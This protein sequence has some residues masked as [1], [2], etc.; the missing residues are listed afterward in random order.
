MADIAVIHMDLM[1]K[2]GGEAVCMHVLESLEEDHDVTL[3]TLSDPDLDALNDYFRTDVRSITVELAGRLG[4]LLHRR[5]DL[6]YYV[7][8]NALLGRYARDRSADFDLQISTINEL[9][10][11]DDSIEYVHFPFDW[12]VALDSEL[13]EQ[14]FHPTIDAGGLYERLCT[15]VA[16][17]TPESFEESTV[18]ANSAWTA[19]AVEN[20]YGTR[21]DVVYPPVDTRGFDDRS[22]EEREPGFVTIGRIE[23]SK[24]IRELVEIVDGVREQGVGTHLHIVGPTVDSEYSEEIATMADRRPYVELE[25]ELP[26]STLV[27]RVCSHRYGIHGKRHE[28]F[29]MAVAELRAGGAIP[30]VPDTGGPSVIVG[31]RPEVQFGSP[32]EAVGKITEVLSRPALQADLRSDPETIRRRFGRERFKKRIASLV[33][34]ALEDTSD[35][36]PRR[37]VPVPAS[38]D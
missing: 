8:Q 7:L 3:L 10:L 6:G 20:A 21:P 26:R 27:E 19:D 5:Y 23:R 34:A 9:G 25:G 1:A 15:W 22:W 29:G 14:I 24:R 17:I 35:S 38:T 31:D 28:H 18:L 4:P 30:F 33:D 11:P 16:G 37:A 2:G 13:R 12:T 36:A 32:E